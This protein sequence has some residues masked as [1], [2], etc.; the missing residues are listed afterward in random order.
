MAS[1]NATMII[2]GDVLG[3]NQDYNREENK[4]MTLRGFDITNNRNGWVCDCCFQIQTGN[5]FTPEEHSVRAFGRF[6][7]L[8][9]LKSL[10]L[11]WK[12]A[13]WL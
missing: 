3:D 8:A 7:W 5:Q 10:F 4:Y 1:Q 2:T 6:I 9:M 11:A 12:S 13:R